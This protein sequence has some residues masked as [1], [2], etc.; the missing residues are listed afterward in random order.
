MLRRHLL[1][2]GL[3]ADQLLE[4]AG[5]LD[6]Y[7]HDAF[8]GSRHRPGLVVLCESAG[9]VVATVKACTES[10]VAWVARGAGTGLSGGATPPTGGV[11][12]ALAGCREVGEV[13][14]ADGLVTVGPGVTNLEISGLVA[15][16]G[17]FYAPDPSSQV[18]CTDRR[19]RGRELRRR[20]LPQVRLHDPPCLGLDLVSPDGE[21]VLWAATSWTSR[22]TTSVG[23][24]VGSEGTLGAAVGVTVRVV[25]KPRA[26]RTVLA[27]FPSVTA[28]PAARSRA[29]SAPRSCPP[30]SR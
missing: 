22:A 9:D 6:S 15:T 28:R 17:L 30:A 1:D 10:S 7:D 20:P 26:V 16:D 11:V 25:P 23:V 19:Q 12:V 8:G 2:S 5:D 14:P 4:S 24:F 29:S 18:V 3:R 13:A 21:L 27:D